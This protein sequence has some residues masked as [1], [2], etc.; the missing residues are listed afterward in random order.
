MDESG[1]DSNEIF[2]YGW[3]EPGQR[4]Q[5]QS[6][7]FG[8]ERL[9]IMAAVAEG[10]LLA[11]MVRSTRLPSL[12]NGNMATTWKTQAVNSG[13]SPTTF[14][15]FHP[16]EPWWQ[17][18]KT[19]ITKELP[20]YNFRVPRRRRFSVVLHRNGSVNVGWIREQDELSTVLLQG[21]DPI[22]R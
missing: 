6:P 19:A 20:K 15:Y 7:G 4:F 3:C 2:P 10:Q 22:R 18:I 16:I 1:I 14:A 8:R 13:I 9:N 12:M 11:P 17:T 5:A 21:C